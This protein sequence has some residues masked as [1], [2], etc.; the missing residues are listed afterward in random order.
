[1]AEKEQ[2]VDGG[3]RLRRV[4]RVIVRR[5]LRDAREVRK[6]VGEHVEQIVL[7]TSKGAAGA[8]THSAMYGAGGGVATAFVHEV[9]DQVKKERAV[10]EAEG[11]LKD[12]PIHRR[13]VEETSI[14]KDAALTVVDFRQNTTHKVIRYGSAAVIGAAV[15]FGLK[16]IFGE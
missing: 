13:V 11:R 12:L 14:L 7:E 5:R 1:M 3:D 6:K 2:R 15:G 9:W 4:A 8:A 10:R 16:K